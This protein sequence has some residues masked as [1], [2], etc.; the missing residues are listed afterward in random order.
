[1]YFHGKFLGIDYLDQDYLNPYNLNHLT[2][3]KVFEI[4]QN[5]L[6]ICIAFKF[7]K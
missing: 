7:Y 3:K 2:Y 1:M 5:K 6:R 4:C